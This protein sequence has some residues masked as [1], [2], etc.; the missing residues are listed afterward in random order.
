[1]NERVQSFAVTRASTLAS[2]V[3]A[4]MRFGIR[5]VFRILLLASC[6][7]QSW[8][9]AI[10][11]DFSSLP[12]S[13]G[14][15]YE[16]GTTGTAES[17]VFSVSGGVLTQNTMGLGFAPE[18][19][20]FYLLPDVL[21][22]QDPFHLVVRARV[23]Q[24]EGSVATNPFGF[25]FGVY[26]DNYAFLVGLS[27]T[28]VQGVNQAFVAN[29]DNT[30]FH[31]YEMDGTPGAGFTLSVDGILVGSANALLIGPPTNGLA[32]GDTT[33]G[34]NALAEVT[35]LEFRQ[36]ASAVPEPSTAA[37]VG[38]GVMLV[39]AGVARRSPGTLGRPSE[40]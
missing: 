6:A 37:L 9:S 22:N 34:T 5:A 28:Q 39:L 25:S 2:H 7:S 10:V 33:G 3:R 8:A 35:R 27:P 14:W 19:A 20:L 11:V 24:S 32:L 30:Q 4:T 23:L 12:S 36:G 31:T 29:I 40:A 26:I 17:S 16:N 18:S 15:I 21:S 1:M 38:I 13:Q